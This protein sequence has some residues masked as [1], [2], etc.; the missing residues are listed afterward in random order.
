[1]NE[2]S[3]NQMDFGIEEEEKI[4]KKIYNKKRKRRQLT[5]YVL[6]WTKRRVIPR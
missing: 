3:S 6:R 2:S 4:E 5:N 1:M